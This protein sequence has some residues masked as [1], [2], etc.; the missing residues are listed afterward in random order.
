MIR[1]LASPFGSLLKQRCFAFA[2]LE[3][4]TGSNPTRKTPCTILNWW[5]VQDDSAFG[6]TL[7]VVAKATLFRFRSTRTCYRFEPYTKNTV[8]H[9]KLVGRAGFEPATN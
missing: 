6:L 7:R 3:P 5:V 8:Y 4:A 1:P 2:P 9:T